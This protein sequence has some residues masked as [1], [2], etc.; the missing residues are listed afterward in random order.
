ML[1]FVNSPK[2]FPQIFLVT[3]FV[4]SLFNCCNRVHTLVLL[5][6]CGLNYWMASCGG[7]LLVIETSSSLGKTNG[8]E[9]TYATVSAITQLVC[10]PSK[11]SFLS[12]FTV[13]KEWNT[14][15][16]T[17]YFRAIA[18]NSNKSKEINLYC[19]Y[20]KIYL[21]PQLLFAQCWELA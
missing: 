5:K 4:Q 17:C 12:L 20:G 3:Q 18:L 9:K 10:T 6:A 15:V 7:E 21:G 8:K 16:S 1:W 2:I 19:S 13:P 11:C 14:E